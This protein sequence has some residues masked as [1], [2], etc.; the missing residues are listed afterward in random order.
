VSTESIGPEVAQ[1]CDLAASLSTV[2]NGI[3]DGADQEL[4]E[5]YKL[6]LCMAAGGLA[7]RGK[8]PTSPE[9][10][11]AFQAVLQSL[12]RLA[13][14]GTEWTGRP[15]HLSSK[16]FAELVAESAQRKAGAKPTDRYL[17]ARGGPSASHLARSEWLGSFVSSHFPT[18]KP[19]GISSYIYYDDPGAGLDPHVDTEIYSV[20]VIVMIS[21]RYVDKPSGLL[22]WND[23]VVPRS[24]IMK[25]GQMTI[26][27]AG[28]VV[29][30]REDIGEGEHVHILTIGFA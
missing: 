25:P 26:L 15:S 1:P 7:P 3:Q 22:V 16:V 21:H 4:Q 23:H 12:Q 13:L 2:L 14:P 5:N 17:L 18:V 20:N 27:N 6:L 28:S 11:Q 8:V 9:R 29:H 19:T 10:M 30:A 24:I